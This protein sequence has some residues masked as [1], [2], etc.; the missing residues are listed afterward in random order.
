MTEPALQSDGAPELIRAL[1]REAAD[2]AEDLPGE[3]IAVMEVCGTHTVA[4]FRTGLRD[5]LPAKV[6]L[7]SGPGCPVC[8]TAQGYV[9][10][11]IALS[12]RP[13]VVLATFG[14]M[15]RVPGTESSLEREGASGADV[16]VVYSVLQALDLARALPERQVV[17]LGVGFETTTPGTAWAVARAAEEGLG[18]FSALSAHKL[19]IPAMEVLLTSGE[20]GVAGFLCP[21]HVSVII[22]SEAYRPLVERFG[23]P[24]IVAGFDGYQMLAGITAILRALAGRGERLGNV[25][26]GAVTPRGNAAAWDLIMRVFEPADAAWR[27]LGVIPASGLAIRDAYARLDA[28][29]RFEVAIP[30]AP[31]PPGCRCGDVIKGVLDPP[32]CPLFGTLCTPHRPVGPCMVSREGSCNAHYRHRR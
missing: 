12:R 20:V 18:N 21:G 3:R 23:V 28:E 27:G 25:Y 31:E 1:A 9:D 19:I 16:R 5:L 8:V 17:F 26:A 7:I 4:A 32:A 2:L 14:D 29:Q 15:V 11:A 24:C 22:G 30:D 13:G 6:R 10:A